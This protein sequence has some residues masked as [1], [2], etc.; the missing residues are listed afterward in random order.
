MLTRLALPALL[1]RRAP[2]MV[3]AFG[4]FF[5]CAYPDSVGGLGESLAAS[6]QAPTPPGTGSKPKRKPKKPKV[7]AAGQ[8]ALSAILQNQGDAVQ[9]CAVKHAL[10]RGSNSV[11]IKAKVTINNSG[12]LIDLRID[13]KLDKGDPA[14]VRECMEK[15]VRGLKFPK[16]DAPL[17]TIERDWGIR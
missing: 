2:L 14:P 1:R 8:F 4:A 12:Q 16:S 11:D 17:I 6:A 9:D 10:N 15:L 3:A 7:S 5:L 13:V